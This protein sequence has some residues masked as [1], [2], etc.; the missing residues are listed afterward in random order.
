MR[1]LPRLSTSA[2]NST[3]VGIFNP[4]GRDDLSEF[5]KTT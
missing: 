5:R 3:L 4:G 1:I 2:G